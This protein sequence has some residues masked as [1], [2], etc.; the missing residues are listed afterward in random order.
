MAALADFAAELEEKAARYR[1][2]ADEPA[3]EDQARRT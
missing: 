3:A 2:V 1:Q